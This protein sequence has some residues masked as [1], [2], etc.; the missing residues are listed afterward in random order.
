MVDDSVAICIPSRHRPHLM[1]ALI[2]NIEDT[3]PE[4]HRL[5]FAVE[6]MTSHSLVAACVETFG[7]EVGLILMPHTTMVQKVN[8][9]TEWSSNHHGFVYGGQDDCTFTEGWLGHALAKCKEIDGLVAIHDGHD[10]YDTSI[11]ST[12]YL[13]KGTI[14]SPD[15]ALH[16]GYTHYYSEVEQFHTAQFRGK[17]AYCPES[18]ILHGQHVQD[19]TKQLNRDGFRADR[20]TFLDRAYLWGGATHHIGHPKEPQ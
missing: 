20:Q 14:D 10:H 11:A 12:N 8:F 2:R 3:T 7:V 15:H 13:K 4:P 6:D 18:V 19:E 1:S 5:Y 16:P 9:L 17:F